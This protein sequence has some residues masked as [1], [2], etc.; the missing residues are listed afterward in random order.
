MAE[1]PLDAIEKELRDQQSGY[2]KTVIEIAGGLLLGWLIW[3]VFRW[4]D[5][6][7][8]KNRELQKRS[9]NRSNAEPAAEDARA[10]GDDRGV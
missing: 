3:I 2:V 7:I 4:R 9:D 1:D 6:R 5:N 10:E 8:R